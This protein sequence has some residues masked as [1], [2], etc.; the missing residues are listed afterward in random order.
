MAAISYI[1]SLTRAHPDVA[2]GGSVTGSNWMVGAT[3]WA[4]EGDGDGDVPDDRRRA[5]R[6][7]VR[8]LGGS[9]SSER[10]APR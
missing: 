10:G 6:P 5:R 7:A 1:T 8:G 4:A 2:A 3:A 9:S